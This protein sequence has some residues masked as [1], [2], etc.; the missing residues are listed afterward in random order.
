VDI[1]RISE[2]EQVAANAWLAQEVTT[3]GGWILRSNEGV[4]RRANCV[5]PFSDPGIPLDAAIERAIDFYRTRQLPAR[6]QISPA[7]V[8][9]VLDTN[10]THRGFALGLQVQVKTAP[11]SAIPAY[12]G[13]LDVR[14]LGSPTDEWL[15]A[16]EKG[17][18]YPHSSMQVR[19]GLMVRSPW[20]KAFAEVVVG[21]E[22]VG[23]GLA[24]AEPPWVGL[25]NIATVPEFRGRGAATAVTESLADWSRRKGA[26][27]MYLQVEIENSVAIRFYEALG[28]KTDYTYWYRD[29]EVKKESGAG[30]RSTC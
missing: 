15:D 5:L 12:S 19:S 2:L 25:F 9:G 21:S 4:T 20:P 17:S 22:V 1:G 3:L 18:G 13:D 23:V 11:L 26:R 30:A 27:E 29:Q 16:Y 7:S 24:V 28:F 10:L 8:P 14:L 6:F